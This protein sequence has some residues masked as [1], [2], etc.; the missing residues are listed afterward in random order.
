[1]T[2]SLRYSIAVIFYLFF[3]TKTHS[4]GPEFVHD[5]PHVLREGHVAE[6]SAADLTRAVSWDLDPLDEALAVDAGCRTRAPVS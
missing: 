2:S 3:Q 5:A 4:V 1:M 6:A